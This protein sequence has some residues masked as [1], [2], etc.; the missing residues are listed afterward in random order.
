M[1]VRQAKRSAAG[2]TLLE[3]IISSLM[4]AIVI[5]SISTAFF[6]AHRLKRTN[7][8]ELQGVQEVRRAIN[9]IKRDLRSVTLPSTNDTTQITISTEET[10]TNSITFSGAM[11]TGTGAN[12][13]ALG[14]TFVEFYTASGL[15][16]FEQPWI[17]I[18]RVIY[19]VRPPTR[20]TVQDGNELVR[21]VTRNLLAGVEED[22]SERVLLRGVDNVYFEFWTGDEWLDYWDST[23]LSPQAPEA[24]R[25]TIT[26]MSENNTV[27][28][29]Y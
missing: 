18:Q 16:L 15:R 11:I 13:A 6:G 25:T 1:I 9:L 10:E 4:F 2:F 23:T 29:E 22:Y 27:A 5:A 7:E 8:A 3:L 20:G 26:M 14:T 12:G 21:T 19:S 28:P 24:I 17:D